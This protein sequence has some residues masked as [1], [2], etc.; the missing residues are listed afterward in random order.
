MRLLQRL[1]ILGLL[2]FTVVR[3]PLKVWYLSQA[4]PI[5]TTTQRPCRDRS[6]AFRVH[7][8]SD[9]EESIN[10]EAQEGSLDGEIVTTKTRKQLV[11][12]DALGRFFETSLEVAAAPAQ[13]TKSFP[14]YS[15]DTNK[16]KP[17]DMIPT[18]ILFGNVRAETTNEREHDVSQQQQRGGEMVLKREIDEYAHESSDDNSNSAKGYG[19]PKAPVAEENPVL[20]CIEA[21][22]GRDMAAAVACFDQENQFSFYDSLYLGKLSNAV[23]LEKYFTMQAELLPPNCQIVVDH[24][25]VD[26]TRNTVGV[27]WRL[28]TEKGT[29]IP[30]ARGVSFYTLRGRK[31]VTGFQCAEM[32]VKPPKGF[33]DGLVASA[34][35][36]LLPR[37]NSSSHNEIQTRRTTRGNDS[38]DGK[39][40]IETYFDAWNRRDME[41]A[42]D[43]F[44][45][46]CVYQTE[47]PVFVNTL[48]GKAAL[49]THLEQ[50]AA[51]LPAGCRILLDG[52]A[53]DVRTIGTTWHLEVN[54]AA[55]PNLRGCSMYTI[56]GTTGRLQ[57]GLD[58][59]EAPVKLPRQA[60]QT[61]AARFGSLILWGGRA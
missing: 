54:G 23:E 18:D 52:L 36:V 3:R 42:L 2:C 56:D 61:P 37:S 30:R 28:V 20:A 46:P 13:S 17:T 6:F 1:E 27:Q 31:I 41:A 40:I 25:A 45:E 32:L 14:T 16:Y 12:D 35:R 26:A 4:F 43:C 51:V 33:V 21:W 53:V 11:F 34:S 58:I 10:E 44:V 8:A 48:Q 7:M 9:K 47:D 59:T 38:P 39:S 22:N 57:T 19:T 29:A 5:R 15:Y 50:N 55:L 24:M 49:R 60:L